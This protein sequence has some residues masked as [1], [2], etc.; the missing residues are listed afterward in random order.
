[1]TNKDANG[2]G[3]SRPTH[4]QLEEIA[5]GAE[6]L[7][8]DP[9]MVPGISA[10]GLSPRE[11]V[12]AT[13]E[14]REVQTQDPGL[15]MVETPLNAIGKDGIQFLRK[16][17]TGLDL[18]PITTGPKNRLRRDLVMRYN[19]AELARGVLKEI[20]VLERDAQGVYTELGRATRSDVFRQDTDYSVVLRERAQY[21]QHLL[22]SVKMDTEQFHRI[23]SGTEALEE[24]ARAIQARQRIQRKTRQKPIVST[25]RWDTGTRPRPEADADYEAMQ[26]NRPEA[27]PDS[28]PEVPDELRLADVITGAGPL[29]EDHKSSSSKGSGGRKKRSKKTKASAASRGAGDQETAAEADALDREQNESLPPIAGGSVGLADLL[30][31]PA[32]TPDDDS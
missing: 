11:M 4:E 1:M 32:I 23:E 22:E 14:P 3:P 5:A 19:R 26:A 17:F 20:V 2:V 16:Q 9:N 27:A 13:H 29:G 10:R 7:F 12:A 15:F 31:G 8:E 28:D 30:S 24:L 21:I 6:I 18:L 25:A